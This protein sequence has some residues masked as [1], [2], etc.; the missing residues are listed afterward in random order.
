M[1]FHLNKAEKWT[2]G[3]ILAV[4]AV[5]GIYLYRQG[6]RL[7][8]AIYTVSG[9][10]IQELSLNSVSLTLLLKLENKGDLSVEI[11]DQ[12]YD[13][14]VNNIKVSSINN[15][16]KVKIHSNTC[17][18]IPL[19]VKFN[20]KDVFKAGIDNLAFL[21]GDRSKINIQIKGKFSFEAGAIR[22]RDFKIDE[23]MTLAQIIEKS[24][25]GNTN[26]QPMKC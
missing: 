11:I 24:K 25:T 17:S 12:T 19:Q 14:Y 3:G 13:I 26:T 15:K 9:A 7:Y 22:M 8:D 20:P 21:V 1:N 2:I 23:N 18:V 16:N 10:V 6:K 5:Y 4:W